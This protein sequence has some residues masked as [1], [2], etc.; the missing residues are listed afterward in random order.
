MKVI[1]FFEGMR[2]MVSSWIVIIIFPW[3]IFWYRKCGCNWMIRKI[4][5][6]EVSQ[7]STRRIVGWSRSWSHFT[8]WSCGAFIGWWITI[9][10]GWESS[11][12]CCCC[13][14]RSRRSCTALWTCTSHK[15]LWMLVWMRV[16]GVSWWGQMWWGWR[17]WRWKNY[18]RWSFRWKHSHKLPQGVPFLSIRSFFFG[19]SEWWRFYA[20]FFKKHKKNWKWVVKKLGPRRGERGGRS[21]LVMREFVKQIA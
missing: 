17:S 15:L 4:K 16:L 19:R 20:S 8:Q 21:W 12:R 2:I 10:L 7:T 6:F 13:S 3:T 9:F 14:W 18:S 5:Q 1:A 11:S